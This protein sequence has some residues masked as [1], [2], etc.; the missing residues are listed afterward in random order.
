MV[1]GEPLLADSRGS[2]SCPTSNVPYRPPTE[3]L[4]GEVART[5]ES[6]LAAVAD[7]HGFLFSPEELRELDIEA[8]TAAFRNAE[9]NPAPPFETEE[10]DPTDPGFGIIEIPA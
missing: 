5:L 6:Q 8:L 2:Q 4:P 1:C 9:A 7:R 10:D 3:A